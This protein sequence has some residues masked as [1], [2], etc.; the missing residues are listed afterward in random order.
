LVPTQVK[1]DEIDSSYLTL[2]GWERATAYLMI[3]WEMTDIFPN[4][5][6]VIKCPNYKIK[7]VSFVS[8]L[9]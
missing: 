3:L 4:N 2:T 6:E 9:F 7:I 8:N 1:A 5:A